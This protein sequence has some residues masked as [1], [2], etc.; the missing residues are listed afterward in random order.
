MALAALRCVKTGSICCRMKFPQGSGIALGIALGT[1]IGLA[2]DQLALGIALGVAFGV[3]FD[4]TQ[5]E[6]EHK[7]TQTGEDSEPQRQEEK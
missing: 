7:D 4:S 6:Q 1:G 3:T 5:K 2:L